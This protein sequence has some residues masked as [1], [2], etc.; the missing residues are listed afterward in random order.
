MVQRTWEHLSYYKWWFTATYWSFNI[1]ASCDYEIAIYKACC[2]T[3]A[4]YVFS[5][6]W[7]TNWLSQ[8][9]VDR[10]IHSRIMTDPVYI[11]PCSDWFNPSHILSHRWRLNVDIRG[12]ILNCIFNLSNVLRNIENWLSQAVSESQMKILMFMNIALWISWTLK[13]TTGK[14]EIKFFG[15]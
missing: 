9:N 4:I 14:Q 6:H 3:S 13:S 1:H 11:L 15:I 8:H 12:Y 10:N 2:I 7:E 5:S